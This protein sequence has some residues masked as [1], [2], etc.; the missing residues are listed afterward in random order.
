MTRAW[1]F[2]QTCENPEDAQ[3]TLFYALADGVDSTNNFFYALDDSANENEQVI[4]D[5][6]KMDHILLR[7]FL[8]RMKGLI[9]HTE[10]SAQDRATEFFA[11]GRGIASGTSDGARRVG[12]LNLADN[13]AQAQQELREEALRWR[14]VHAPGITERAFLTEVDRYVQIFFDSL[15]I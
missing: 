15:E 4:C 6:G 10:V 13:A 5:M 7:L 1:L 12:I 9:T 11:D 8:P 14:Q 3:N 2:A